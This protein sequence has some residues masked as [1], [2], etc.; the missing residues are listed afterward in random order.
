MMINAQGRAGMLA[1]QS[2]WGGVGWGGSEADA[3]GQR[4]GRTA[5]YTAGYAH[6]WPKM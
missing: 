6:W 3:G 4:S 1:V 2:S 5:G